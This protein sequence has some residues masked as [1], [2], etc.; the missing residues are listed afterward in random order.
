MDRPVLNG[1][2]NMGLADCLCSQ[3]MAA[4]RGRTPAT[5]IAALAISRLIAGTGLDGAMD[6]GSGA[7]P[8]GLLHRTLP[9]YDG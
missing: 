3:R 8:K 5:F 2:A 6:F 7:A 1:F 4:I 9:N